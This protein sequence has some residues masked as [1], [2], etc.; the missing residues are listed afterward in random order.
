MKIIVAAPTS[1]LALAIGLT[2]PAPA[3]ANLLTNGSFEDTT[4]FVANSGNDTMILCPTPSCPYNPPGS[5]TSITGWTVIGREIA[6]IGPTNP[7][8]GSASYASNGNYF[9]DLT[10]YND[11]APYGGVSQT[12]ATT[13]GSSYQLSF[14]LGDDQAYNGGY[15]FDAI[16]ASAGSTS[17][18]FD[19]SSDPATDDWTTET[20][21]FTATGPTTTISLIG[22]QG[23]AFIGLDNVSVTSAAPEPTSL[24]LLGAGMAG[25]GLIRRKRVQ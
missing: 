8:S 12:I 24:A 17:Q 18:T 1:A 23:W 11:G 4:N 5:S 10:G 9:L 13:S 16:T 14:D 22:A 7:Y 6:W 25:L 21:D 3:S 19:S 2:V 15:S 20:L